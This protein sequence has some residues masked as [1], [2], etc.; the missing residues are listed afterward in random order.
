MKTSLPQHIRE[1]ADIA[2]SRLQRVGG[3]QEAL[4][5]EIDEQPRRD[6]HRALSELGAADLDVRHNDDD[7]LAAAV[8]CR[9]AG[10]VALPYPVVEDL[11]T[12]DGARLA[13]VNPRAAR[14]NHGDLPGD[15]LVADLDGRTYRAQLGTRSPAKL[16][17][18]LVPATLQ[19]LDDAVPQEDI[20]LYLILGSWLILGAAQQSLQIA[21]EHVRSR[22]QFRKPLSEFQAVRFAVADATVAIR[23]LDELAKYTLSRVVSVPPAMRSAD[24]IVLRMKAIDT[25]IATLRTSHQLLGALGF[26]DES[27][28]SVIDRHT[29]PMLRLPS[30]SEELALRLLPGIRDG[31]LQTLFTEPAFSE[32][33]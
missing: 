19:E 24:A 11:L 22:T 27:D 8:L 10:A 21:T 5:A 26:C 7:R 12:V 16:G 2:A 32:S 1:F 3:P 31:H 9:A 20:D 14:I 28:I 25:A 15:W 13:L 29:Q 33:A 23:G 6:A 4:H 17:P 18:F 30:S